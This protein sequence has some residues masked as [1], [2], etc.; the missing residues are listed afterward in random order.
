[1]AVAAVRFGA[2]V[3]REIGM[4]LVDRGL[5][6]RS[7]CTD[8]VVARLPPAQAVVDAL[9]ASGVKWVMYDRVHVEPTEQPWLDAIEFARAPHVRRDRRCWRRLVDR[10]GKGGE[11]VHDAIRLRTS[12]TT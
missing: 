7:S 1:M 11:P 12:S 8:P 9:D 5:R 6:A 3:T 10:H 4:E 2:G